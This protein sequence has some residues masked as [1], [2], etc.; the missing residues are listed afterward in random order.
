MS[1][2]IIASAPG[3][4]CF[5]G[6]DIDWISGP[7]ILC[8]VNLRTNIV[9]KEND[10]LFEIKTSGSLDSELSLGKEEIGV[11]S[12]HVLDYVNA[13][14]KIVKDYGI[15]LTPIQI[16]ISSDLPSKAGLSSSA[17]VSV[18]SVA[19]ISRYYGLT[20][21]NGDICDMAYKIES[22]ELKTGAG[23]MDMYSCGIGSLIYINSSTV[24]PKDIEKFELP[25]GF[26]IV[27][28]DTLTP[29]NTADV[30]KEK[31]KR[32]EEKETGIMKYVDVTQNAI[33]E[34]R[35]VLATIPINMEALG[36]LMNKCH[37]T[38]KEDMRVSTDLIE[39]GINLALR[40]GA[41]GA[42]LTG[43]GMGGCFFALVPS[44]N[45]RMIMKAFEKL[46]VRT[47]VTRTSSNGLM[48]KEIQ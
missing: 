1:R 35:D 32:Y 31:R 5:A 46:P 47:Y 42:K 18:A 20:L 12:N 15:R 8:A 45:T 28:V 7:S 21:S 13:A 40:K 10:N 29:R 9:V 24:P 14:I 11:Y 27:I 2:E 30:I 22:R 41:I 44:D 48:I 6:E 36:C 4:V 26:D 39:E 16:E 33:K 34:I 38:L 37:T 43:T 23:Q 3:R 17:A 25:V 19:A